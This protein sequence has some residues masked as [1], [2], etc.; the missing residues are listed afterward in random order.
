[1]KG[2]NTDS[3]HKEARRWREKR[4]DLWNKNNYCIDLEKVGNKILNCGK[5]WLLLSI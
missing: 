5:Q 3:Y 2:K 4:S 1:M